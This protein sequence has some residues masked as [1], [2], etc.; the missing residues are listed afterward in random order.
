[1]KAETTLACT[2]ALTAAL[3][4]SPEANA[5]WGR[6]WGQGPGWQGPGWGGGNGSA[7]GY[8]RGYGRGYGAGW[9]QEGWEA[10][11][12]Q[13]RGCLFGPRM[14]YVLGVT[15][16]QQDTID[17]LRLKALDSERPLLRDLDR[18]E[19]ELSALAAS[20]KPDE[21][22]AEG[23]RKKARELEGKIDEVW[24]KYRQQVLA[25]LTPEQRRQYD[26][27]AVTPAPYGYAGYGPGYGYG[28]G[29]FG[30]WGR[31]GYWRGGGW[32]WRRGG[33]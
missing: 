19:L 17:N 20:P 16:A 24:S 11:G 15:R 9:S 5:Q 18:T 7:W 32:G 28:R 26:E 4:V 25:L 21:K 10:W 29:R 13:G 2:L 27:L 14:V 33:W 23:L 8:G 3:L 1:M 30:G 6:G 22:A 31:G 12:P